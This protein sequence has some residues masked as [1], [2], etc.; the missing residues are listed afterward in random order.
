MNAIELVG[1]SKTF[2]SHG[3]E[4]QVLDDVSLTVGEGSSVGLI[5]ESGA[6]KSTIAKVILGMESPSSGDVLVAGEPVRPPRG[7][8][9]RLARARRVQIVF[10]D[11][12]LSL[13]PRRTI[14]DAIERS[15]RLHGHARGDVRLRA[16]ELLERVGLGDRERQSRPGLLSG[17]Q[18]QR[19]A[20]ARALAV[21]PQTLILDEAVAALDVSV[22]AQVLNLLQDLRDEEGLSYLFITHNLAVVQYITEEAV[23]LR[24]GRVEEHGATRDLLTAP[25]TEYTRTLLASMPRGAAARHEPLSTPA[26][27]PIPH[28]EGVGR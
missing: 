23:V 19:A 18:R 13:N 26:A 12:Y 5:G 8:A 10:Q 2:G 1:V 22:Q 4:K 16:V 11:P 28:T 17:G 20:I 7:A 24:G 3:H 14:G 27:A 9:Q 21:R 6:G 25:R 15:L